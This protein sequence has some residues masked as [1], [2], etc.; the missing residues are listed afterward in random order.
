MSEQNDNPRMVIWG[1]D[2]ER[3]LTFMELL[4][5]EDDLD[6]KVR[7][8]I[9]ML[10]DCFPVGTERDLRGASFKQ[11]RYISLLAGFD[12]DQVH[13]FCRIVTLAG[14]LDS[15]QAHHLITKLEGT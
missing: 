4:E 1:T 3:T 8:V 7:D 2:L 9:S 5:D 14:G 11:T 15:G 13:E 6:E 12:L 10:G